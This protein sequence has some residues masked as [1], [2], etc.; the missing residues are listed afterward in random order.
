MSS[1]VIGDI[2]VIRFLLSTYRIYFL[3]ENSSYSLA[4]T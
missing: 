4:M 1:I 3:Y 2:D